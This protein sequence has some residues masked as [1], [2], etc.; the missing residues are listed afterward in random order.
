[1]S[2]LEALAAEAYGYGFPMVFN[3]DE[4]GRFTRKGMGSLPA[5][6]FNRF[7]HAT[8]LAGP[9]DT[10]VSVN[11][12]T[13]YSIAQVDLSGGPLLLHVPDAAGRYYVLQFV[14]AWTNN[15]AYVGRRATGT[16]AGRYLLTGPG[17]SGE[18]PAG[19]TRIAAPTAVATI[20]G[21]WAC[22]G[23]GDLPAVRTLQQATTLEPLD[24]DTPPPAGLPPLHDG[25]DGA[26]LLFF[27]KLRTWMRAF[28]PS[29]ADRTYQERFAPLGLLDETTPYAAASA[30]MTRALTAGYREGRE[31]VEYATTHSDSPEQNGWKLTYN[32]FD[33]NLDFFETGTLNTPRW[34]IADRDTARIVRAASAR[35]G[36]WGNH[37]YEA[38]YAMTWNDSEGQPLD[39]TQSYTLTFTAPPPVDAFWSITMY[40]LPDYYL[41]ANPIDRYSIG[42]RTPDLHHDPD[43]SLTLRLQPQRPTDPEV[44]ANWLPTPPGRFRPI[45]RMYQPRPAVFDG[46]YTLP[47]ITRVARR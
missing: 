38:A 7:S 15:F 29:A 26:E 41:I 24:P 21:R 28:P 32:A 44:A 17:W 12:D 2:D 19:V 1:M 3:L 47:P 34:V 18:I 10:F 27:E 46:T 39:G 13:V 20:V 33:Y 11:N 36:L 30:E 9:K 31:R 22:D 43:G 37:A 42:D 40:D 23:P 14:D 5:S 16:A 6:P 4:V 8:G 25:V 35:A 45:L